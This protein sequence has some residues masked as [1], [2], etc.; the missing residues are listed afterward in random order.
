MTFDT[1]ILFLVF[2]RPEHTRKVFARIRE[3]RPKYLFV[4][5]DGPRKSNQA[6]L[7]KCNEIRSYLTHAIDWDCELSTL[8]REENLGCGKGVSSAI[9]WFFGKVERGIILEDDCMP[10]GNFFNFSEQLL[11]YYKNDER[12]MHIGGGTYSDKKYLKSSDSYYFSKYAYCWGWATWGRAWVKYDFEMKDLRKNLDGGIRSIFKDQKEWA[13]WEQTLLTVQSGKTDTW[14][15]QWNYAIWVN[16]GYCIHSTRNFVKNIGFNS[17]ATH[18]HWENDR[19]KK[20]DLED[21]TKQL[22]HPRIIEIN[23]QADRNVF[24]NYSN[25]RESMKVK[26]LLNSLLEKV[27]GRL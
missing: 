13:F 24:A 11:N 6:D 19:Y 23:E 7:V 22:I 26:K 3:I 4:A 1:P 12:I 27:Y 20:V 17:E 25:P 14:D 10:N 8:F 9:T 18:T 2:N 15:F 21:S 5:A 16:S